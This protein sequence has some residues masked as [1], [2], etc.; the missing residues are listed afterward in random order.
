[1]SAGIVLQVARIVDEVNSHY[2]EIMYV[3]FAINA[4]ST[5]PPLMESRRSL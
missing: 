5:R 3:I 4:R 1:M 2:R